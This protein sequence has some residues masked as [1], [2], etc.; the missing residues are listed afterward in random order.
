M[1]ALPSDARRHFPGEHG[2]PRRPSS[3]LP[4]SARVASP[5]TPEA[6]CTKQNCLRPVWALTR[7][8]LPVKGRLPARWECEGCGAKCFKLNLW[9]IQRCLPSTAQTDLWGHPWHQAVEAGLV[10]VC[11][12]EQV[13]CFYL[14]CSFCQDKCYHSLFLSIDNTELYIRRVGITHVSLKTKWK[15][16]QPVMHICNVDLKEHFCIQ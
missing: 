1:P 5:C 7:T 16:Q 8:Y 9:S 6:A 14:I 13:S 3:E 4:T 11:W 10:S 12:A 2:L 15:I